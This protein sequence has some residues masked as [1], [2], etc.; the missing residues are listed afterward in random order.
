MARNTLD[1]NF[2]NDV[3]SGKR[4]YKMTNNSDGTVSFE[5]VTDY[6]QEGSNWNAVTVNAFASLINTI[7]SD[8]ETVEAFIGG[9]GTEIPANA[10]INNYK[11]PGKYYSPDTARTSTL[12]NCPAGAGFT[13]DILTQSTNW[14]FEIIIQNS[15]N[16]N[17]IYVRAGD[18]NSMPKWQLIT[19]TLTSIG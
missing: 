14:I 19:S 4:K 11:T 1:T 8:L 6:T 5:D 12:K 7:S 13:L 2:K 15:N 17:L 3:F 16:T 9:S 10:D 18:P